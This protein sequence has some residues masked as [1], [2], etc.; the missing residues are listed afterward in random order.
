MKTL[1]DQVMEY[2]AVRAVE[3]GQD[4]SAA[5]MAR[6]VADH[7][8]DLPADK[9]CKRQN[10]ERVHEHRKPLQAPLI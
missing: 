5:D 8:L 3:L 10:I 6:E 4:F 7:Q 1:R 9:R 2:M